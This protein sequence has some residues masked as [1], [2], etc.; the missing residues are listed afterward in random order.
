MV[1]LRRSYMHRSQNS[2]QVERQNGVGAL[3]LASSGPDRPQSKRP[4]VVP[5]AALWGDEEEEG[6]HQIKDGQ[7]CKKFKK[8]HTSSIS[9]R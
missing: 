2:G 9:T 3:Q 7:P 8:G 1:R 4:V 6:L 5:V